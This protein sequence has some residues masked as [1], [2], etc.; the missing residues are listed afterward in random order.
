MIIYVCF[1]VSAIESIVVYNLFHW[2][3]FCA[4][5][6]ARKLSW[7]KYK[8]RLNEWRHYNTFRERDVERDARREEYGGDSFVDAVDAVDVADEATDGCADGA[9][10]INEVNGSTSAPRRNI[11]FG[12]RRLRKGEK[13]S[14]EGGMKDRALSRCDSP[15]K[16]TVASILREDGDYGKALAVGNPLDPRAL[17][18]HDSHSR[19]ALHSF[20]SGMWTSGPLRSRQS[21]TP[22]PSRSSSPRR[23]ATF[24]CFRQTRWRVR[25]WTEKCNRLTTTPL[26]PPSLGWAGRP[27]DAFGACRP[28]DVNDQSTRAAVECIDDG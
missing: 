15:G 8:K 28:R 6:E 26:R 5:R 1:S 14:Q 7:A 12:L 20:A 3:T 27:V 10:E 24:P 17:A 21:A 25:R 9:Y 16:P 13:T 4:E 19:Y 18:R 11:G 2:K 22:L 23:A